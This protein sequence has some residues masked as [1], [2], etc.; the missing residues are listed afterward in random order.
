MDSENTNLP[1]IQCEDINT[2]SNK[3]T[4]LRSPNLVSPKLN[5]PISKPNPR[6]CCK[7]TQCSLCCG[8][9]E[10]LSNDC[11]NEIKT[12][13]DVGIQY[14]L[15]SQ[16]S[17]DS[18]CILKDDRD[19]R[20]IACQ[21]EPNVR[22]FAVQKQTV[23]EEK[24]EVAEISVQVS[25]DICST[26]TQ[27][28]FNQKRKLLNLERDSTQLHPMKKMY[29]PSSIV[30][31]T[32]TSLQNKNS[33]RKIGSFETPTFNDPLPSKNSVIDIPQNNLCEKNAD[34]AMIT[35]DTV[36]TEHTTGVEIAQQTV[37]QNVV[38]LPV[39]QPFLNM[40]NELVPVP[41]IN[42]NQLFQASTLPVSQLVDWNTS[43][44]TVTTK[45]DV[46]KEMLFVVNENITSEQSLQ[47]QPIFVLGN[48]QIDNCEM[49]SLL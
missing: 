6:T 44:L 14:E 47:T 7:G 39:Q 29:T 3:H 20:D 34:E 4:S 23:V 26:S 2:T 37:S 42:P 45:P 25:P 15:V 10:I 38:Q 32:C 28:S 8:N 49:V 12:T 11:P 36:N 22:H 48:N 21:C 27:C 9:K 19:T 43:N 18:E 33:P 41:S 16:Y 35:N 46:L 31:N 24:P 5:L 17:F 40:Q 13:K 30:S 1:L